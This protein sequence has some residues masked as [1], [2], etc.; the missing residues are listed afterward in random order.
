MPEKIDLLETIAELE[1]LRQND[2]EILAQKEAKLQAIS[3]LL[4][5][6]NDDRVPLGAMLQTITETFDADSAILYRENADG[7]YDRLDAKDQLDSDLPLCS[8]C[9]L[10][11]KAHLNG[12]ANLPDTSIFSCTGSTGCHILAPNAPAV[13]LAGMQGPEKFYFLFVQR[14]NTKRYSKAEFMKFQALV[15]IVTQAI[16]LSVMREEKQHLVQE[17]RHA[18]KLEA[19]GQLAG[20]I[21]HEINTP[22]QYISGNLRFLQDGCTGLFKLID[23]ML[24]LHAACQAKGE[25]TDL[26]QQINQTCEREDLDYLRE[27]IPLATSQSIE[28]IDHVSNIVRAMKEFAHPGKKEKDRIDINHALRNTLTISRNEWKTI[29]TIEEDLQVDLPNVLGLPAELNQVFLNIIV[30]AAHAIGDHPTADDLG[31]IT[32]K[33]RQV[34]DHVEIQISDTGIGIPVENQE[35]IFNPF[36][37]TKPVGKGTGQ[38]LTIAYDI[39]TRKHG[40]TIGF[41][42]IANKGTTFTLCLPITSTDQSSSSVS[43]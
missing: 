18:Q 41:E 15:P 37:T 5:R 16:S 7:S 28:G 36:F 33:T 20:G 40:G 11:Q 42:S 39:V 34:D 6:S 29:A 43:Q 31:V 21:A 13:L 25:Y 1:H 10:I 17:L 38:G 19:V 26:C 30:N 27:E 12:F 3:K 8:S 14:S 24:A 35:K 2:K 9:P 4:D 22:S 32:I 23:D